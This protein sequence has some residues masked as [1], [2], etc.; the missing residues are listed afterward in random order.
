[1][2]EK[3]GI[4]TVGLGAG[5]FDNMKEKGKKCR[6]IISGKK[7]TKKL[8]SYEFQN[9]RSQMWWQLRENVKNKD[10]HIP[11]DDEE[12]LTDLTA[13]RYEIVGDKKIKVESK[14]GI[15]QRLGRSP[16]KGDAVVYA[17]AMRSGI[18]EKPKM[19]RR[20]HSFSY[21]SF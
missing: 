4:D 18:L 11:G 17:N 3:C 6:E 10:I 14:D 13:P 21:A 20:N 12:L 19:R 16:D 2:P 9:L 5:V 8:D 1:M 7:P 15:K